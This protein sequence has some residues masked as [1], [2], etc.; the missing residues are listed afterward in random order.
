M[1]IVDFHVALH[2]LF[3]PKYTCLDVWTEEKI[4]CQKTKYLLNLFTV[5]L[6]LW[7]DLKK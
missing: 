4:L 2:L 5:K 7:N 3:T 6:K 1:T